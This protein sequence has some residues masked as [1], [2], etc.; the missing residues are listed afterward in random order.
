MKKIVSFISILSFFAIFVFAEVQKVEIN[1]SKTVDAMV[2]RYNKWGIE[3]LSR[4]QSNEENVTS[5]FNDNLPQKGDML[6][7]IWKGTSDVDIKNLYIIIVDIDENNN[8]THLLSDEKMRIPVAQNIKGGQE[9]EINATKILDSSSKT[10]VKIFL[11]CGEKDTDKMVNLNSSIP[12]GFERVTKPYNVRGVKLGSTKWQAEVSENIITWKKGFDNGNA[13]WNFSDIDLSAYER[14]RVEIES[15][16][17]SNS[18]RIA[19]GDWSNNHGFEKTG[20]NVYEAYLSGSNS[21]DRDLPPLEPS[22]GLIICFDQWN[23]GEPRAEDK[24]TVVKSI[25]FFKP[26]EYDESGALSLFGRSLGGIEDNC[27]IQDNIITWKKGTK[28]GNAGWNL[29]GINLSEYASVKITIEKTDVNLGGLYISD[30]N[31]QKWKRMIEVAP[32]TYELLLTGENSDSTEPPIDTSEGVQLRIQLCNNKPLKKNMKTIVKSIELS[33]DTEEINENLRIEG[34]EFSSSKRNAFVSDGGVIDW[35]W[36][37]KEKYP[38]CGWNVKGIDLSDY[39][40]IR[41]ELESTDI[42][43][44]IGMI[45]N[46][47]AVCHTF[48]N[49]K[50]PGVYEAMFDGSEY[51]SIWPEGSSWNTSNGIEEI[52]IRAQKLSKKGLKTVV[53]SISL[54]SKDEQEIQQPAQL[55][56]NGAKLGSMKNHAWIGDDFSI[57]WKKNSW[58]ECGWRV[59]KLD[60]EVLEIKVSSSDVPLRLRI[61]TLDYKNGVSYIDDGSHIFKINLKTKKQINQK[62]DQKAPEWEETTKKVD[63]SQGAYITLE[64]NGGVYKEGKK[65][66]VEYIKVE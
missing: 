59:E 43:V 21:F 5:L 17:T 62:G 27:E 63:Y 61:R 46:E 19:Q 64:T 40:G 6:N 10:N 26:G 41:I 35:E 29:S 18:L 33:K 16:N 50:T 24:T 52:Q 34:V 57:N 54:I 3:D 1:L 66:V 48:Y 53:K 32:N 4:W 42:P 55:V 47:G 65:T 15:S 7:I 13:G 49:E 30:R 38:Y 60:G 37:K 14:V 12:E 44:E 2:L 25:K 39:K 31:A 36:D 9:F 11:C 23:N 45:Q 8:W 28:E 58:N 22:K 56:L 20:K 51:S